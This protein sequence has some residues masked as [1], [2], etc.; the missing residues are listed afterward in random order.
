MVK[1]PRRTQTLPLHNNFAAVVQNLPKTP[2]RWIINDS[3]GWSLAVCNVKRAKI[4]I[5]SGR[6]QE[7]KSCPKLC[8]DYR[9]ESS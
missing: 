7:S 1:W 8:Q 5:G 4:T 3:S 2:T 9:A 6:L